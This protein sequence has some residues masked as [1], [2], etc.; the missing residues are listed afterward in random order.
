MVDDVEVFV[1]EWVLYIF[2]LIFVVV[3]ICFMYFDKVE[4]DIDL[5]VV[6]YII[7]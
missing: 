6:N 7:N 3:I 4:V 2:V 5:L 1:I